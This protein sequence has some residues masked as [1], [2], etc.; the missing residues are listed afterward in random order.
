MSS[1]KSLGPDEMTVAFYRSEWAI[2]REDVVQAVNAFYHV[3][4]RQLYCLNGALLTLIPK[5]RRRRGS[6]RL[7]VDQPNSQL[8]QDGVKDAC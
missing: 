3:D 6:A 1:D 2:I 4:R 7:Q 8:P 5:K